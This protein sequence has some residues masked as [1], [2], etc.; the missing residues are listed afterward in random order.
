MMA[1]DL[2]ELGGSVNGQAVIRMTP[3]GR[4]VLDEI[5]W[6]ETVNSMRSEGEL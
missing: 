2:V 4:R 5:D 3:H 1:D 6:T